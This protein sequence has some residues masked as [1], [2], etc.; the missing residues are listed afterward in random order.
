MEI[1][2]NLYKYP[3]YYEIAFRDIKHEVYVFEALL[4]VFGWM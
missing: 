2:G 1:A 3:R 4:S